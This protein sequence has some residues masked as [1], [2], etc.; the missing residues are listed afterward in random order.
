MDWV[1]KGTNRRKGW[2]SIFIGSI[3]GDGALLSRSAGIAQEQVIRS[4]EAAHVQPRSPLLV[5]L[6]LLVVLVS[7]A[8]IV[9]VITVARVQALPQLPDL[10]QAYLPGNPMPKEVSC[11]TPAS[12]YTARCSIVVLGNAVYFSL[13]ADLKTITGTQIPARKYAIGQL[14]AG[15]GNPTGII[16]RETMVYVHWGAR[17]AL[18]YTRDFQ[19][20]NSVEFIIYDLE[21]LPSSP[22]RGFR[23]FE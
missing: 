4:G 21:P 6:T 22:W 16:R 23:L 12:V 14:V 3:E 9:G 7:T 13:D 19:P 11:Y 1:G 20:G 2:A 10:P 17:S 5:N 8:L 15:W 18:I